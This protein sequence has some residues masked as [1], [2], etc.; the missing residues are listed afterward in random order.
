M[1]TTGYEQP[2]VLVTAGMQECRFLA[3]QII[4]E[5]Y[6]CLALPE[7][8]HPGAQRA[9]GVRQMDA[10]LLPV[11][12]EKGML[13]TLAGLRQAL[14]SGCS[15]LYLESPTRL[16][17][18]AF[19][20][21]AV[22]EI[23][24]LLDEFDAAAI[25]DQGLAPWVPGGQY[26]SLGAQP[27]MYERVA[28][29]GEAWPGMGL[30]SW[31]VGYVA[32]NA[33]WFES[34]RSQKQIIS[35]CTSTPSQFAALEAAET[36]PDA[37]H[38]QLTNLIQARDAALDLVRGLDL[39]PIV[40]AATNVIALQ[41]YDHQHTCATLRKHGFAF[42]DGTDFGAEGVLRLSVIADGTT[43]QALKLLS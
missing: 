5:S 39:I 29:L 3:I 33:N 9:A 8:V 27:G 25:W 34:I 19:D 1:G 31:F 21:A 37:H 7:V 32:A 26:V 43:E 22:A 11:D 36:Y 35:I 17:G 20:A 30:E 6:G 23:A 2:N 18:A 42:A 14:E 15:L 16:S 28:L 4:G 40:G 24:S 13:P 38:E 12:R 10:G 41:S